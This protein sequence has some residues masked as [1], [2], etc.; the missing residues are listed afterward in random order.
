MQLG[1]VPTGA[2]GRSRFDDP[3]RQL[4]QVL[5]LHHRPKRLRFLARRA[6]VHFSLSI[7]NL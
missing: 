2:A 4:R 3:A 1:E 6:T 5:F 7:R